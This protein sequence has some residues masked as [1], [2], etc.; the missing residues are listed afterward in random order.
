[1]TQPKILFIDI[2]SAP[3][4]AYIWNFWKENIQPDRVVNDGFLMTV[5]SKWAGSE[6]TVCASGEDDIGNDK[7]IVQHM[8]FLLDNADIVVAHNAK[9]FDIP[10]FN[11]R[12]VI[13][14][15]KPPSPYRIIDTLEIARKKFKFD[16]NSLEN[17]A[18]VLGCKP[19]G[20]HKKFPGFLLW[21]EC[22]AGNMEAWE[23]MVRYNI[24]DVV[25][26]EQVYLKL[27]PWMDNHPN[28]AHLAGTEMACPKCGS[29]H[30]QRRGKHKTNV[31]TYQRYQCVDCGG[32]ARSRYTEEP[33]NRRL[34]GNA[35]V[36]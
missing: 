17:L 18:R 30:L 19:K 25:T 12:C 23:E 13:N 21:K 22:L 36:N 8:A 33:A 2:E 11:A 1:M 34:L 26:L 6:E 29:K 20:K 9:K 24:D 16:S 31:A 4:V 28:V 15:I 27:R 10:L 35:G 32:W 5:A 14:G 3:K 7:H